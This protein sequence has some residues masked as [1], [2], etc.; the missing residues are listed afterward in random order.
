[1][2]EFPGEVTAFACLIVPMKSSFVLSII[3]REGVCACENDSAKQRHRGMEDWMTCAALLPSQCRRKQTCFFLSQN[4]VG[5]RLPGSG[6]GSRQHNPPPPPLPS[7]PHSPLLASWVAVFV[8]HPVG[9][10]DAIVSH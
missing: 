8:K 1:M 7:P 6:R 3:V 10:A 4:A 2:D 9:F 5:A